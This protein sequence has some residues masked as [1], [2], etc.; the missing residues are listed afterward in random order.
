MASRLFAF[1]F[2]SGVV[3]LV[4]APTVTL[5][6][7]PV[8]DRLTAIADTVVTGCVDDLVTYCSTVTPGE[9]R[10]I[11]CIYAHED[12]LSG[13][14]NATLNDVQL[15]LHRVQNMLGYV[16]GQCLEDVEKHCADVEAG[17]GRL[18]Q[19]LNTA[20]NAVTQE[21]RAAIADLTAE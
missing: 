20:G 17:D 8:E 16:A 10:V 12:K 18:V 1:L 11:A 15:Q 5:T 9:G 13:R 21:C 14:C 3:A 4:L 2:A 6:Q 7:T 19:C